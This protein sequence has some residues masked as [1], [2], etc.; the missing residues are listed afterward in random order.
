MKKIS[1]FIKL[2]RPFTLLSPAVGFIGGGLTA[3]SLSKLPGAPPWGVWA[4]AAASVLLN[5]FSNSLNQIYDL[6][7]DRINCPKRPLPSGSL[8]LR[9]AGIFTF[10]CLALS[11]VIAT[12]VS[13]LLLNIFAAAALTTWAYSAPPARTKARGMLGNL[14]I[15]VTR[16]LLLFVAGWTS[17]ASPWT[18]VPWT[19][20]AVLGLFIFGAAST[21]D[22][23]D[24]KG[25]SAFG[26]MTLPVR[27]GPA[28][29]ARII[30]PFLV[31][32]FLL[33]PVFTAIGA[34]PRA[35]LPLSA[36]SLYGL[37][38]AALLLREHR[39]GN[40]RPSRASW[41]H[42]YILLVLAQAGFAACCILL[43]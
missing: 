26:I 22:F 4:G 35:T 9:D 41:V 15:A 7:I 29:A 10:A 34:L 6:E 23:S 43:K 24:T 40:A 13:T 21:K 20:G 14:T 42:M 18:P 2:S 12:A 5:A 28:A 25:D 38:I 1:A 32:P 36:L 16:G 8:T 3:W 17:A 37:F 30:A 19:A 31:A 39:P 27:F 11:F 33:I